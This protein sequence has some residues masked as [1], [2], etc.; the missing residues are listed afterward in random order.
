MILVYIAGPLRADSAWEVEQ[1]VRRAEVLALEVWRRGMVAVCPHTNTRFFQGAAPDDVWLEG[2]LKLL[3]RCDAVLTV[4]GWEKSEGAKA[5]V[6]E[7]ERR[8]I[9]VAHDILSLVYVY[10]E[11]AP[12]Y[13]PNIR[14]A[15][16]PPEQSQV[17]KDVK[18]VEFGEVAHTHVGRDLH[19]SACP[20][21]SMR[22]TGSETDDKAEQ[23]LK[24][25]R[26]EHEMEHGTGRVRQRA[27]VV[28]SFK[29]GVDVDCVTCE[30]VCQECGH[31]MNAHRS[32]ENCK[33]PN[34]GAAGVIGW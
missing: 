19:R 3:C 10:N 27:K 28:P 16:G 25:G 31:V 15:F 22:S 30:V 7:A 1:N 23:A 8:G 24:V 20:P 2:Y 14:A 9:F 18:E 21:Q 34:C 13:V 26:T 4:P 6:K 5:E 12:L 17:L 33:C 11:A 32:W 29:P